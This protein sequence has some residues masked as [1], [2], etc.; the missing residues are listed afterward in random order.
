MARETEVGSTAELGPG[1]VHGAGRYAVG[2]A[3]GELFA[4]GRRCRHLGA[5]LAKGSI[6]REGCLVCPWH[7]ARFEVAT[8]QMTRSAR[9]LRQ[10]PRSGPGLPPV[11][12]GPPAEARRSC[13]AG[14][15]RVR[16][17]ANGRRSEFLVLRRVAELDAEGMERSRAA[18]VEE[19]QAAIST[20]S[21]SA[22]VSHPSTSRRSS[23]IPR[24][25]RMEPERSIPSAPG[26][27]R[28]C[29]S[30]IRSALSS[31]S[32]ST[33]QNG[34]S[35]SA[36]RSRDGPGW[37]WSPGRAPP[38]R[39]RRPCLIRGVMSRSMRYG[40]ASLGNEP[41]RPSERCRWGP[42]YYGSL[43]TVF[44]PGA[45]SVPGVSPVDRGRHARRGAA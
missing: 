1:M 6:D 36:S 22:S 16:S 8:G 42:Q 2:N 26:M 20:S 24:A 40:G 25:S 17:L 45:R 12:Q 33:V 43:S 41:G 7:G 3:N 29:T 27:A 44:A 32:P 15:H 10:D 11:E 23:R 37:C 21:C 38:G 35:E 5:D 13:R 31:L 19:V 9:C 39:T 34:S 28:S 4:V 30:T 18:S 14:R